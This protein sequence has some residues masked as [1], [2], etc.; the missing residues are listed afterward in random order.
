MS[1]IIFITGTD[2]GVGKTVITAA[3]LRSLLD[4]GINAAAFKPVQ[5]GCGQGDDDVQWVRAMAGVDEDRAI[6]QLY[7]L[8]LPASPHLAAREEGVVFD[9]ER[10]IATIQELS[11]KHDTLL[12][13][14]A[15]GLLVPL[16]DR[17]TILD[18]IIATSAEVLLVARNALGTLNHTGLSLRELLHNTISIARVVV[19]EVTEARSDEE[20]IIRTD[21]IE[22]IRSMA[23]PAE[24]TAIPFQPRLDQEAIRELAAKLTLPA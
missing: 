14:G 17:Q 16:D 23:H 8:A 19:N 15:G 5:T 20:K 2:T 24:V 9:V 6:R 10:M 4:R 18:L 21:N 1:R 11:K 3:L 7:R 22:R 12:V 13:E